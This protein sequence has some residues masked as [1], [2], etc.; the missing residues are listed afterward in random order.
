MGTFIKNPRTR[1]HIRSCMS[2]EEVLSVSDMSTFKKES[3][4]ENGTLENHNT[5]MI[6]GMKTFI[7]NPCTIMHI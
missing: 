3:M 1:M 4:Y 2:F 7:E 5:I 6:S